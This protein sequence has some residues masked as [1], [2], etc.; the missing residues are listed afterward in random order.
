MIWAFRVDTDRYS[1]GGHTYRTMCLAKEIRKT[2]KI[3]FFVNSKKDKFALKV[4]DVG[5][6]VDEFNNFNKYSIYGC[7]I[8]GYNFKRNEIKS[9]RSKVKKLVQI[10]DYGKVH[11]NLDLVIS[12]NEKL[13]LNEFKKKKKIGL[14]FTI[15]NPE[16]YEREKKIRKNV[17]NVMISFGL[18]DSK[19]YTA[20]VLEIIHKSKFDLKFENIYVAMNSESKFIPELRKIIKKFKCNVIMKEFGNDLI[21]VVKSCDLAIGSGGVGMCERLCSGIPS[22]VIL[23]SKNQVGISEKLQKKKAIVRLNFLK[24]FDENKF[25]HSLSDILLDFQKRKKFSR[26]GRKIFDGNGVIRIAKTLNKL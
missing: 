11:D 22:I 9:I 2:K 17:K 8:D 1:G 16:F 7:V 23:S 6:K 10:Y 3:I 20:K 26:I 12:S 18:I 5:F 19:N 24:I 25:Q 13:Q 14:K 15:I 4:K 21:T